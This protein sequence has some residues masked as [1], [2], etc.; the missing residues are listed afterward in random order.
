MIIAEIWEHGVCRYKEVRRVK[1][2]KQSEVN[3]KIISLSEDVLLQLHPSVFTV[4]IKHTQSFPNRAL[5]FQVR[6]LPVLPPN[7]V[8][9]VG[10]FTNCLIF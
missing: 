5:T 2:H 10:L 6:S 7:K 8:I 3:G 4:V 9:A 1:K